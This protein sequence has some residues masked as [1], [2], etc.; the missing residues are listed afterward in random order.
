MEEQSE[1]DV[2]ERKRKIFLEQRSIRFI[3]GSTRPVG[4]WKAEP[5][6]APPVMVRQASCRKR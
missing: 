2:G 4:E 5:K 1:D 6:H 3:G